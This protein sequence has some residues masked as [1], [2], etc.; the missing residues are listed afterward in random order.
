M[1]YSSPIPP[2]TDAVRAA[3]IHC[4]DGRYTQHCADFVHNELGHPAADL[5]AL[6]GGPACMA[7]HPANFVASDR[8]AEELKF[9][10]DAHELTRVILIAHQGCGLYAAATGLGDSLI[11]GQQK[12]DLSEAARR[13]R[14]VTGVPDVEAWFLRIGDDGGIGFEEFGLV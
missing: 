12:A 7:G 10:V 2:H 6:P 14:D 8:I 3:V 1:P 4:S 5:I 13:I 11:E 9:L